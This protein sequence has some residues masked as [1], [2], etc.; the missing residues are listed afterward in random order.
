MTKS[1]QKHVWQFTATAHVQFGVNEKEFFEREAK[2]MCATLGCRLVA[3][4]NVR[5]QKD[6]GFLVV[7][8]AIIESAKP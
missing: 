6:G 2:R 1:Q 5:L 4:E 3:V 7:G 8:T